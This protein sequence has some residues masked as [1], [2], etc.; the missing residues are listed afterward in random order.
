M[1][2]EQL[3]EDMSYNTNQ[4]NQ[5]GMFIFMFSM[6]QIMASANI[7]ITNICEKSHIQQGRRTH[8]SK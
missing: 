3:F 2:I 5:I 4:L 8:Q 6:F 7:A 1:P